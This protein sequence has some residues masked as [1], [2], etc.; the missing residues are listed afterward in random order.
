MRTA[1]FFSLCIL[2]A[3]VFLSAQNEY[4]PIECRGKIPE[5]F[6]TTSHSK[7][8]QADKIVP[9]A[10]AKRAELNAIK[11]FQLATNFYLD[12]LLHSGR[13]LF[14]DEVSEYLADVTQVLLKA[15]PTAELQNVRVYALRSSAVNAFATDRGEVFVT[16]GLLAQLENEAQLAYIIAHELVHVQKR[17]SLKFLLD[18]QKLQRSQGRSVLGRASTDEQLFTAA[19]YSKENENEAD[20]LGLERVLR[21]PYNTATLPVVYDVLKYSY[22]PFDDLPFD[23][24]LLESEHYRLPQSYRLEDVKPIE[25]E[26]DEEDDSRSSHPNLGSRRQAMLSTLA[27]VSD[28]EE[29]NDYVVSAE[30]F[31]RVRALA[32]NEMPLL[33]LHA[34]QHAAA[35]YNAG[36]LLQERPDDLGLKKCIA[37]ALYLHTKLKNSEDYTYEGSYEEIEGQS[38]QLHYLL[39]TL[40]TTESTVLA[41]QYAWNLHRAYPDDV[42]MKTITTDLFFE[43]VRAHNKQ[44]ASLSNEPPTIQPADTPPVT[45]TAAV[46]P[47]SKYDRIRAQKTVGAVSENNYWQY[48]FAGQMEHELFLSYKKSADERLREWNINE[49]Y[50]TTSSGRRELKKLR[51]KG[52]AL[53]IPKVVVVN[54]FYIKMDERKEESVQFVES[55]IGQ[56]HF[57]ELIQEVA[58]A[59]GLQTTLIDV[60]G[61]KDDETETFNDLRFLNEWFSEQARHFDLSLTPGNQQ[62]RIDSIAKKY[63]TDY[64]LWTGVVSLRDKHTAIEWLGA[65]ASLFI[66][67][68]LSPFLFYNVLTPRYFTIYYSILYDVRTGRRSALKMNT[69]RERAS[70]AMVKAHLYDAFWQIKRKG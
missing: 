20:H 53:D 16:L 36:L 24:T 57:S 25:G 58:G 22:L 51:E 9:T 14:N 67:P 54:P 33:H 27:A 39:E 56:Q 7:Y 40:P 5:D 49:V 37:K 44:Y 1:L 32:R 29:K 8:Q 2:L 68:P 45:D 35:I 34:D 6:L 28:V 50:Y 19:S 59:S 60:H 15:Q 65:T 13:V 10:D 66:I 41:W 30:R 23:H 62:A 3:P 52:W 21:S 31:V 42:E 11:Q 43:F 46:Q 64:F 69:Y 55:E 47:Q 26:D 38:Q 18:K 48:A 70:D 17:H 12:Q 61:L 4:A 63:D